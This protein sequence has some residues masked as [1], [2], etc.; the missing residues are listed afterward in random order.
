MKLYLARW[1]FADIGREIHGWFT[2]SPEAAATWADRAV[3]ERHR[4]DF[5]RHG[6]ILES[7]GGDTHTLLN[8]IIESR[9]DGKLV[10]LCEEPYLKDADISAPPFATNPSIH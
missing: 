4:R 10:L 6:V 9:P 2:S 3:A 5:N 1:E 8:L 7:Q